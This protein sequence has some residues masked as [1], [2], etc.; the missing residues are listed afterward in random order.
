MF[1]AKNF[2]LKLEDFGGVWLLVQL[3]ERHHHAACPRI[4]SG[5]TLS[6]AVRF[7]RLLDAQLEDERFLCRFEDFGDKRDDELELDVAIFRVL[8]HVRLEQQE[9]KV[10]FVGNDWLE[11]HHNLFELSNEIEKNNATNRAACLVPCD[12]D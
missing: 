5:D 8:F 11:P 10:D 3:D 1:F 2:D 6:V 4:S 12:G 7:A 9:F